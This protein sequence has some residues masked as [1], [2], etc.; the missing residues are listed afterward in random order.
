MLKVIEMTA[1]VLRSQTYPP[2]LQRYGGWVCLRKTNTALLLLTKA[3]IIDSLS[4]CIVLYSLTVDD[5]C[6]DTTPFEPLN[7][8]VHVILTI[9]P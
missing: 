9:M 4:V 8:V 5:F 1:L 3:T 6:N 7:I 2:Y